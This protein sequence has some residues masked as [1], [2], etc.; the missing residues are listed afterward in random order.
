MYFA[1]WQIVLKKSFSPDER[2]FL[3][4]LMR[5]ARGNVRDHIISRK[6]DRTPR[7]GAMDRCS[8]KD[9][10]KSTFAR[11]WASFVFRLLQQYRHLADVGH[12]TN[13]R[14]APEAVVPSDRFSL[15]YMLPMPR[16]GHRS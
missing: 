10:Q 6:N 4:P 9:L 12:L 15:R 7:I 5:F 11:F 14:S 2:N 1:F 16:G 13:V 8:D 3:G